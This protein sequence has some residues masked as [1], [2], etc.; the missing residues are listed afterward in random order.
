MD[1]ND[2]FAATKRGNERRESRFRETCRYQCTKLLLPALQHECEWY[3]PEQPDA[4]FLMQ[5]KEDPT[6]KEHDKFHLEQCSHHQY[7]TNKIRTTT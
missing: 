1:V 4:I 3:I 7:H 6:F 5:L 2:L